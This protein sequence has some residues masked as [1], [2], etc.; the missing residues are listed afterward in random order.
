MLMSCEGAEFRKVT[1]VPPN[2]LSPLWPCARP[3]E[4]LWSIPSSGLVYPPSREHI[5]QELAYKQARKATGSDEQVT[6]RPV[7]FACTPPTGLVASHTERG[8][9]MN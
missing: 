3:G 1:I 8:Q 7:L 2:T 4:P 5:F 6:C 9:P